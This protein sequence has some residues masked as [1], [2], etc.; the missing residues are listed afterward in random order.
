MAASVTTMNNAAMR[1]K[2]RS[3]FWSRSGHIVD[4]HGVVQR[5]AL[6]SSPRHRLAQGDAHGEKPDSRANGRRLV[7]EI[8]A[9]DVVGKQRGYRGAEAGRLGDGHGVTRPP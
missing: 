3:A 7:V 4:V 8:T 6:R 2:P 1:A 9:C 5:H